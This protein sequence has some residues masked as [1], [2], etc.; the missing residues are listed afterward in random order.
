M[1]VTKII[2]TRCQI[3]HL[4]L[5]CTIPTSLDYELPQTFLFFFHQNQ[6][7]YQPFFSHTLSHYQ[8]SK[9]LFLCVFPFTP[10]FITLYFYSAYGYYF[11]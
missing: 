1:N 4:K 10:M 6:K 2:L 9:L 5:K 3:F 7:K 11:Q 8:T